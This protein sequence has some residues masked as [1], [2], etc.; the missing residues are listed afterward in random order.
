MTMNTGNLRMG[1]VLC[2]VLMAAGLAAC[3]NEET[4]E[5]AATGPGIENPAA[6]PFG[7]VP[8]GIGGA[9]NGGGISGGGAG[10][11]GAGQGAR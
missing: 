4:P 5:S 11:G 3:A 7:S 6:A 9:G 2:A 1:L 8:P 10:V